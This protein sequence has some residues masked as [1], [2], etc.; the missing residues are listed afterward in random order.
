ML[1]PISRND[2]ETL[3][4]FVSMKTECKR[5]QGANEVRKNLQIAQEVKEIQEIE[6]IKLKNRAPKN[7]GKRSHKKFDELN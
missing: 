6:Q 1:D 2:I 3:D 4:F 7:E 5:C